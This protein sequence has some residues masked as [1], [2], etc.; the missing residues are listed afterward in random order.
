VGF[1]LR[2][3]LER[4]NSAEIFGRVASEVDLTAW[5][6]GGKPAGMIEKIAVPP[7]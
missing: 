3:I 7:R 6:G 2:T 4:L 5:I 1:E